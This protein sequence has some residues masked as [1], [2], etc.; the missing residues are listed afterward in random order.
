MTSFQSKFICLKFS[1]FQFAFAGLLVLSPKKYGFSN[2]KEDIETMIYFWSVIGYMLGIDDDYNLFIGDDVETIRQR[3]WVIFRENFRPS[4]LSV[5]DTTTNDN[6]D[7]RIRMAR[8]IIE[9]SNQYIYGLRYGSCMK[10]IWQSL[11]IESEYPLLNREEKFW[12]YQMKIV[13]E[14][15]YQFTIVRFLLNQLLRL[16]FYLMQFDFMRGFKIRQLSQMDHQVLTKSPKLI[17]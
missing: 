3:C 16:S 14:K 6:D 13:I 17:Q 5:A 9:S 10:F 1:F 11:Q 7:D 12:Y 2:R 8:Q 15:C 4:L